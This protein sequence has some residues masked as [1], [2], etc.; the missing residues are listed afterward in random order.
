MPRIPTLPDIFGRTAQAARYA[1]PNAC[2]H[3]FLDVTYLAYENESKGEVVRFNKAGIACCGRCMRP[4][5]RV[6]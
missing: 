4:F 2:H 3:L 5:V 6:A 1:C